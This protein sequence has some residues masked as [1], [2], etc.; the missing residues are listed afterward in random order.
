MVAVVVEWLATPFVIPNTERAL[1][2]TVLL[3]REGMSSV[4][5]ENP[6]RIG[7]AHTLRAAL[8]FSSI[9]QA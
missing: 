9:M 7:C 4:V 6:T 2:F 8:F 3:D 1:S 5:Y